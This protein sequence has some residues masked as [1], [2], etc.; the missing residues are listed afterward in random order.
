[1][2]RRRRTRERICDIP[3]AHWKPAEKGY[4]F[5]FEIFPVTYYCCFPEEMIGKEFLAMMFAFISCI[6]DSLL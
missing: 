4:S 6:P 3:M 2:P 1:M 5:D